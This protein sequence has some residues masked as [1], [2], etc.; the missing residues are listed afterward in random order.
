[1]D[2]NNT[3]VVVAELGT[4]VPNQIRETV[5]APTAMRPIEP[6]FHP[7]PLRDHSLDY[8]EFVSV[9]QRILDVIRNETPE[10]KKV[11]DDIVYVLLEY[12]TNI[13]TGLLS[14]I[15]ASVK[16]G[17]RFRAVRTKR[18]LYTKVVTSI[19]EAIFDPGLEFKMTK[20]R[21]IGHVRRKW[22]KP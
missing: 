14:G 2:M 5:V 18:K 16:I 7:Q 9:R 11:I 13:P 19:I 12:D 22:T 20:K 1:M 6:F 4:N 21:H 15:L 10:K 17:K 8:E 3:N